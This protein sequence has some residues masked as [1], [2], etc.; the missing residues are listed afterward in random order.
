M[1]SYFVPGLSE[2]GLGECSKLLRRGRLLHERAGVVAAA[3][4]QCEKRLA[5]ALAGSDHLH[6]T[7]GD[8]R[9]VDPAKCQSGGDAKT[10]ARTVQIG[11]EFIDRRTRQCI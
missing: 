10:D 5:A 8:G 11:K 3:G 9:P 1:T 4:G 6:E 2:S 7:L